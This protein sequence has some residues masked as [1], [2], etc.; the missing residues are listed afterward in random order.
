LLYFDN[1]RMEDVTN[2]TRRLERETLANTHLISE[3][4]AKG[5]S[6][7]WCKL[8]YDLAKDAAPLFE[9]M[10]GSGFETAE[11]IDVLLTKESAFILLNFKYRNIVVDNGQVLVA[12]EFA[13]SS[14]NYKT[15]YKLY[16]TE[17]VSKAAVDVF[18]STAPI[19]GPIL[20]KAAIAYFGH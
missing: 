16:T 2:D 12:M 11:P 3:A 17:I 18:A 10:S 15:L 20:A 19:V 1:L 5:E 8:A 4:D 7:P 14:K 13:R 6:A 9:R